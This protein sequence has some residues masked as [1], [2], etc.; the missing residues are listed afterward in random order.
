MA[1]R[2]PKEGIDYSGW[3][4]DIFD[5]DIKIDKLL[6][7]QGA[8]GFLVYF[9]LCQKAYGSSGYYYSWSFDNAA[10]TARKIGG[11]VGSD[12]V[13]NT[14]SLCFQIGL[15]D[16]NLFD[17]HGI[18][19]SKGIQRRYWQIAKDRTY[20]SVI[21]DYWLLDEK[22]CAGV[23]FCTQNP[24]NEPSKLNYEPPKLNYDYIKESK[25]KESKIKVNINNADKPQKQ[26][27]ILANYVLSDKL[28]E[29]VLS[30]LRYKTEKRQPYKNEGLTKFLSQVKNACNTYTEDAVIKVMDDSMASNYQ[31][32][33]WDKL[34][35][36]KF[37][38]AEPE[39]KQQSYDIDEFFRLASK[40][41]LRANNE[42]Q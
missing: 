27:D 41:K 37:N 17:G 19:T 15:F 4:V 30:W 29:A 24:N 6:D 22:D 36:K 23:G 12:T 42:N 31:G 25:V 16:K 34:K 9:Y 21:K 1:G 7:A 28:K 8:C 33:V 3:A 26:E 13:K 39:K 5:N 2:P 35:D 20:K 14:V 32:V 10:T 18:I 38:K 40:R 11:G